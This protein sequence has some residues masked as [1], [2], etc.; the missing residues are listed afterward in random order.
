MRTYC[1]REI[2][3]SSQ[4]QRPHTVQVL[5]QSA[6]PAHSRVTATSS[7]PMS[8]FSDPPG[9]LSTSNSPSRPPGSVSSCSPRQNDAL[10][11]RN[12]FASKTMQISKEE[13]HSIM[14]LMQVFER[15]YFHQPSYV[16]LW[17]HLMHGKE[18]MQTIGKSTGSSRVGRNC[19]PYLLL[20][21]LTYL[22]H[23]RT[24]AQTAR[25]Y[26]NGANAQKRH[27]GLSFRST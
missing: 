15:P 27:V 8:R 11:T 21:H 14:V 4:E 2:Q 18:I 16:L 5:K 20:Y 17:I 24:C 9:E 10:S 23:A 19:M 22:R 6:L 26:G 25:I 7:S 1:C 12:D 3:S 13:V